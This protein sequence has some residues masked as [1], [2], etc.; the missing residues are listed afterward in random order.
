MKDKIIEIKPEVLIIK[1]T[2]CHNIEDEYYN[3]IF[4]DG[5]DEY[6]CLDYIYNVYYFHASAERLIKKELKRLFKKL[7]GDKNE[8]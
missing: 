8:S 3:G 5:A 7:K 6:G 1:I 4:I 2:R